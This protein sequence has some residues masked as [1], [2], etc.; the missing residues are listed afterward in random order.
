MNDMS[1]DLFIVVFVQANL[2]TVF[3][4]PRPEGPEAA[5][6]LQVQRRL[7]ALHAVQ[8]RRRPGDGDQRHI[9]R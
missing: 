4:Q 7:R 3:D 6:L 1:S 2:Q 9:R 5:A 8:P